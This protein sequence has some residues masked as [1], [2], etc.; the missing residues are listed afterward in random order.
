MCEAPRAPETL[1]EPDVRRVRARV[2]RAEAP[3]QAG[4]ARGGRHSWRGV[5]AYAQSRHRPRE[6]CP[7]RFT[8]VRVTRPRQGL[9]SP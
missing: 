6:E 9:S 8:E 3:G 5:R 4:A 7:G 2:V 1:E